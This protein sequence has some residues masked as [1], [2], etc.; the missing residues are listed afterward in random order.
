MRKDVSPRFH[1]FSQIEYHAFQSVKICEICGSIS[2]FFSSLTFSCPPRL[3]LL[4]STRQS[5]I[6]RRTMLTT[7]VAA[8]LLSSATSASAEEVMKLDLSAYDKIPEVKYPWGWL[9]WLM[10][11]QIDPQAE[12]TLA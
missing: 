3:N 11:D 9:R 1:R 5:M 10:N 12:L 8:A 7:G 4:P 2:C 6:T